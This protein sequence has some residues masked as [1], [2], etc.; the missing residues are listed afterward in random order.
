MAARAA[1]EVP[2]GMASE[3][4]LLEAFTS[5]PQLAKATCRPYG[6]A[7]VQLQVCW[8]GSHCSSQ[9]VHPTSANMSYTASVSWPHAPG[10]YMSARSLL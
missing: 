6:E 3:A 9:D 5:I 4:A 1:A 10:M 2:S 8:L 7:G